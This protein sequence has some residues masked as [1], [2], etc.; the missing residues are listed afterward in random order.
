MEYSKG[1]PVKGRHAHTPAGKRT[2]PCGSLGGRFQAVCTYAEASY[3]QYIPG[4]EPPRVTY[5]R[6]AAAPAPR[7]GCAA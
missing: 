2:L 4:W 1:D 5:E 6:C 3:R 7:T